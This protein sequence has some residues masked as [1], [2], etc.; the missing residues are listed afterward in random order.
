MRSNQ[1]GFGV[2]GIILVVFLILIAGGVG[3]GVLALTGKAPSCP[4]PGGAARSEDTIGDTLEQGSV[5]ITDAEATTLAQKY[6]G[7]KV[8][9]GRVCFTQ[10]LGHISGK[11]NLG[12]VSPSF[13]VSG[14]VDLTGSAPVATNLNIQLGSLP[15]LPV[16]SVI[17]EKAINKFVSESLEK[18]E[19]NQKYSATFTNGSVTI[20]K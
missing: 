10:G 6:V 5:T 19:L 8:S 7:D 11:I 13:Y 9:D 2:V 18:V 20:Q 14:G 12:S 15:N 17:A 4:T 16:V 3:A 1:K